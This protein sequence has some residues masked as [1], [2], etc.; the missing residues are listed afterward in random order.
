MDR[1][2][3]EA[4]PALADYETLFSDLEDIA[5]RVLAEQNIPINGISIHS[6]DD[7][8][9]EYSERGVIAMHAYV[10]IRLLKGWAAEAFGGDK[11]STDTFYRVAY[12]AA[13]AAMTAALVSP[14]VTDFKAAELHALLA[15]QKGGRKTSKIR[16]ETTRTELRRLWTEGARFPALITWCEAVVAARPELT[17]STDKAWEG[18]K[19]RVSKLGKEEF[20]GDWPI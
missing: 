13:A 5:V 19:R 4:S 9:K 1:I 14:M 8:L 15:R 11:V 18:L 16:K 12:H 6:L 2:M 10:S 3:A 7:G 17:P 20:K